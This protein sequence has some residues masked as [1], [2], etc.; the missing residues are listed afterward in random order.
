MSL[1]IS[2]MQLK[3]VL[4]RIN[5]Y[6]RSSYNIYITTVGNSKFA[7]STFSKTYLRYT[8]T[9]FRLIF[10]V[11]KYGGTDSVCSLF[12]QNS[13]CSWQWLD[14]CGALCL[15]SGAVYKGSTAEVLDLFDVI[16]G[17]RLR[18]K[19][20]FAYYRTNA[21][22]ATH[23]PNTIQ[24]HNDRSLVRLWDKLAY[25]LLLCRKVLQCKNIR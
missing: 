11:Y 10:R 9:V 21:R 3:C 2:L 25:L 22:I 12:G 4:Y 18:L 24:V 17:W 16:H 20:W 6:I 14:W 7:E 13:L 8:M 19:A 15:N 1:I 5:E 23:Q